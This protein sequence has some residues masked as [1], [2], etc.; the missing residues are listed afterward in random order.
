MMLRHELW[1]DLQSAHWHSNIYSVPIKHLGT[2][3]VEIPALI[4]FVWERSTRRLHLNQNDFCFCLQRKWGKKFQPQVQLGDLIWIYR[5]EI[6]QKGSRGGWAGVRTTGSWRGW[7]CITCK[8]CS[9]QTCSAWLCCLSASSVIPLGLLK[10]KEMLSL[11]ASWVF[12]WFSE[13]TWVKQ[14]CC[15]A[16]SWGT[17]LVVAGQKISS[18]PVF[19]WAAVVGTA[20]AATG[21]G[22]G[23]SSQPQS[24]GGFI[25]K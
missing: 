4:T 9:S 10:V 2:T 14:S 12:C 19:M 23:I 17:F 3:G 25:A 18:A 1:A 6:E 7:S 21:L 16:K 20:A 13:R 11:A 5:G 8:V 22:F 24:S 15:K